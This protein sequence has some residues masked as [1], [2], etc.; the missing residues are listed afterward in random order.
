QLPMCSVRKRKSPVSGNWFYS[1]DRGE[2]PPSEEGSEKFSERKELIRINQVNNE[3][4]CTSGQW[5]STTSWTVCHLWWN[6][7]LTTAANAHTWD[8]FL[9]T[10]NETGEREL[11]RLPAV[12]R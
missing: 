1:T 5:V 11:N 9:P 8:T 3:D 12:P 6:G 7:Q 4:Q 10:R 2:L